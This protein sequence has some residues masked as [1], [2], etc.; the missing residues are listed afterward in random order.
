MKLTGFAVLALALSAPCLFGAVA[1]NPVVNNGTINYAANR[2]TLNGSGFEPATTAPVVRLNGAALV[3]DSFSNAEIVAT[4]PAK[5]S[6]GSYSLTVTNSQGAATVFDLTYGAAGP[7]GPAGPAGAKGSQGATGATGQAGLTGATGP[8]GPKG[9]AGAPGGVLSSSLNAQPNTELALPPNTQLE[10]VNAIY[11]ENA[12]TY[13][14]GGQEAFVNYDLKTT[15]QLQCFVGDVMPLDVTAVSAGTPQTWVTIPPQ[16][17]VTV[18]LNGFYIAQ[19]ATTL[20]VEC[21]YGTLLPGNPPIAV[22]TILGGTFT[23]IQV[24]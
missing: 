12:G 7:Q 22:S 3:L 15:A 18:P 4:L 21:R 23:A 8:Q 13:V 5:T 6:A 11:L 20:Y 16:G 19:A 17:W 24:K 14:I 9:P 2:V 10:T 1:T